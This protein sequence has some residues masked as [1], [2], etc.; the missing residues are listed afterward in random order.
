VV[1]AGSCQSQFASKTVPAKSCSWYFMLVHKACYI[2]CQLFYIK[3][4]VAIGIAKVS[5]IYKP[6]IAV[7]ENLKSIELNIYQFSPKKNNAY[8]LCSQDPWKN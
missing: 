6:N 4:I 5:W 8:L 1:V 7:V 2:V 3:T